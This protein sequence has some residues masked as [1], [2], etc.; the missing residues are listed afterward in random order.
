I[1]NSYYG[2]GLQEYIS[3]FFYEREVSFSFHN[4]NT[5][6]ENIHP[7][8]YIYEFTKGE[9]YSCPYSKKFL[10]ATYILGV[11][12]QKCDEKNFPNCLRGMKVIGYNSTLEELEKE[13]RHIM[14]NKNKHNT[15][16]DFFKRMGCYN[17]KKVKLSE[18]EK[19]II[20]KLLSGESFAEIVK[21]L[22][23]SIKTFYAHKYNISRKFGLRG[24]SEFVRFIRKIV[25]I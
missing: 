7:D 16:S 6:M 24:D 14:S 20:Q 5:A 1:N 25:I 22:E 10:N 23:I 2:L 17:C 11:T 15:Q 19:N 3:L 4:D 9:V 18:Q 21:Q 8:I 13:L 12:D